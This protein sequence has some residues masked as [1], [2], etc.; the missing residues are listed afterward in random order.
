ME[1]KNCAEAQLMELIKQFKL[2]DLLGFAKLLQVPENDDFEEF[3]CEIVYS[4]SK[5]DRRHRRELLKLAKNVAKAN[6][7]L[8]RGSQTNSSLDN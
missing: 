4:F 8:F 2:L 1:K 3:V 7:D 5:L 6:D